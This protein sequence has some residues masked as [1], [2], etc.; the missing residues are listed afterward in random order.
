MARSQKPDF[1]F[2]RNGRVHLNRR[3]HQFSPVLAPEVCSSVLVILDT[4]PSVVVWVHWPPTPFASFPFTS[5]SRASTCAIRF[6]T[7][8][9]RKSKFLTHWNLIGRSVTAHPV[10][11]PSSI[12]LPPSYQCTL[13]ASRKKN[14]APTTNAVVLFFLYISSRFSVPVWNQYF[15]TDVKRGLSQV[16]FDVR[17]KLL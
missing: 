17:Y 7:N 2:R 8:S 15:C 13:I 10:L 12:L 1:F 5:P 6:Q 9:T 16:K 4:P 3:G 11:S 14:S